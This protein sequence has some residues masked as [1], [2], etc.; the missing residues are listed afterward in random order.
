MILFYFLAN[1]LM[2][3]YLVKIMVNMFNLIK[4]LYFIPNKRFDDVNFELSSKDDYYLLSYNIVYDSGDIVELD[5]LDEE[6]LKEFESNEEDVIKLV[7]IVYLFQNTIYKFITYDKD[8]VFPIYDIHYKDIGVTLDKFYINDEDFT[9]ILSPYLG[10]KNNFYIDKGVKL[11]LKDIFSIEGIYHPFTEEN[12]EKSKIKIIDS[13]NNVI[14]ND[15]SW[16]PVWKPF[17]NKTN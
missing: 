7:Q 10:P 4:N 16:T 17:K 6:K 9:S 11:N 1:T 12:F 2:C 15:L 13:L 8:I 5:E 3:F 14:E